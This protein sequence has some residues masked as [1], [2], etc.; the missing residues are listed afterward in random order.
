MSNFS[1][2]K[3][4]MRFLQDGLTPYHA[5]R[6]AAA[7]LDAAGFVRSVGEPKCGDRVYYVDGGT[8]IAC[9]KSEKSGKVKIAA[10]HSD[11]PCFKVK[12]ERALGGNVKKLNVEPYG[13]GINYTFFDEPLCLAGRAFFDEASDGLREELVSSKFNVIIPSLAVHLNRGVNEN[14]APNAQTEMCPIL[15]AVGDYLSALNIKDALDFDLFAVPNRAPFLS[16]V[17]SEFLSSPRID[18][19]TSVFASVKALIDAD[20]KG[21][22]IVYVS[23]NEEIGSLTGE[24][25]FSPALKKIYEDA[26]KYGD[27]PFALSIDNG[28][29]V[30]PNYESK[31]DPVSAPILGGG[32]VIKH[33]S[34]YATT[35]YSAALAKKIFR[36]LAVQDFYS[37]SDAPCGST[38]GNIMASGI[39]IPVCDIGLAQLAMH[40]A[41]ETVAVGDVSVMINGVKR[42]Y[43]F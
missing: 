36:G 2:I 28:H 40:S 22:N 39:G 21:V 7:M 41:V 38:V 14:F 42:L 32:I 13:G 43:E 29:A 11:S 5:V 6:A 24:G 8:L 12:G 16:G 18:N 33:N 20:V 23:N 17:N 3:E 31:S 10:S 30:H 1:E 25:A 26:L 27:K 15:G 4:L 35:G 34:R 9:R 37:R 19:L